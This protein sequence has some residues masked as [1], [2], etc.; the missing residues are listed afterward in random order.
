MT[1][2]RIIF[3]NIAVSDLPTSK[4]FFEGLGFEFNPAFT[5]DDAACMVIS[6]QAFAMLHTPGSFE[7]FSLRPIADPAQSTEIILAISAESREEVD[8]LADKALQIGGSAAR[9]AE[10]YG[11]MYQRSFQ[12]P[13]G[14]LWEVAWMDPAAVESGP[15]AEPQ[16]P[17]A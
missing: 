17:A 16:Q 11:F 5:N 6:E 2:S 10:D 3:V 14:H 4:A 9:D 15:P 1:N 12:D 7:R 8:A 13:D